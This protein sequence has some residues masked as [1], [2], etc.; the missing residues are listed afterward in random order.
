MQKPFCYIELPNDAYAKQLAA[1]SISIR[2][3]LELWSSATNYTE[4]HL[5]L[6]QY[7]DAHRTDA[8]FAAQFDRNVSF[9][10]TV[11]TYNKHFSQKEKV[12]KI[13]TIAYLPVQGDANLKCPDIEWYYLEFYGLDPTNVPE[14]PDNIMFG[15]WLA[16]GNRALINEI[17]LKKRKFIGNTS[18]DATLS[19]FMANQALVKSGDIVYDPFVG[20]G[21]LLVA[22]AKCGGYVTGA[23]IDF[24]M[25]H[26]RTKPTR[27]KQKVNEK[28]RFI[29]KRWQFQ[30][31][32]ISFV[33][34]G[35]RRMRFGQFEA[36]RMCW[37]VRR[38]FG[39]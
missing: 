11:E 24:L 16:D 7:I 37:S 32:L 8:Q 25:L 17:T 21:S 2:C 29:V 1:R 19:M 31:D 34:S 28:L 22:A 5:T 20:S 33:G 30:I 9:R 13:E 18:M 36:V 35:K 4:F 6:R 27:I 38:R 14:Q 39:F 15:K 23:D 12:E 26:G 3:I 10:V